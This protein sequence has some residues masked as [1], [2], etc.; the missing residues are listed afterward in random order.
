MHDR[1]LQDVVGLRSQSTG[2]EVDDG[3]MSVRRRMTR[4]SVAHEI[5]LG[6]RCAPPSV[7]EREV[8][9]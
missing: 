7:S 6:G 8:A 3:E 1:D 5:T 4:G 9:T 2:L